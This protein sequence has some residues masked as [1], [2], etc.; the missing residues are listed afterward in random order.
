[1]SQSPTFHIRRLK[2][3]QKDHERQRHNLFKQL[4]TK[5]EDIQN[6]T[7]MAT[8]DDDFKI[9]IELD[10]AL[11][12]A[13]LLRGKIGDELRVI[14]RLKK[15]IERDEREEAEGGQDEEEEG[16]EEVVEEEDEKTDEDSGDQSDQSAQSEVS[17]FVPGKRRRDGKEEEEEFGGQRVSRRC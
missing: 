14:L 16:E 10:K 3:L 13:R 4:E 1:M 12:A 7:E 15:A 9:G 6:Y 17:V 5:R 11:K 2:Q 8:Y